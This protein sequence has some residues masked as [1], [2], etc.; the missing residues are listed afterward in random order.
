LEGWMVEWNDAT[1][2]RLKMFIFLHFLWGRGSDYENL[3]NC[4]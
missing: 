1:V 3:Y 2:A 4:L